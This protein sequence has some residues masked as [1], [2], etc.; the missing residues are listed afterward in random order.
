[1]R[2]LVTIAAASCFLGCATPGSTRNAH[3]A[4]PRSTFREHTPRTK[5]LTAEVIA[6]L[7]S[8]SSVAIS[9]DGDRIAYVVRT[10]PDPTEGA[11]YSRS[12]IWVVSTRGGQPKRFSDPGV[13]SRHP[14]WSKDG[15]TLA[16]LSN[17]AGDSAT[18]I[19]IAPADGGESRVLTRSPSSIATFEWSPTGKE[20]AYLTAAE[21][22]AAEDKAAETGFD[23]QFGDVHGTRRA[24]WVAHAK[25]GD[26]RHVRVGKLHVSA[27]AWSPKGDRFVLRASDRAD[28]DGEMMYSRL[29]TTSA[30][31]GEPKLL[32]KT[33]GKL[34]DMAWSEDGS[35]IAF[36]GAIDIHDP[37]AG[38][39]YVVPSGG[40]TKRALSA[41]YKGTG[42]SLIAATDQVVWMLAN[43]G[44]RTPMIAVTMDGKIEPLLT[45]RGLCRSM[46]LSDRRRKLAASCEAPGHPGEVFVADGLNPPLTRVT[47]SNPNLDAIKLGEREIIRWKAEDGMEIEGVVTRPVGYEKGKKYPLA[48]LVH[49]GPEGVSL[50]GFNTRG[51][52]PVQL[53]ASR[54]Y[55][56]LEPNYRGSQGRGVAFGKADQKDL[57]GKEFTDVI[58]GIDHLAAQGMID[59]DKVGMGGWSYGGYFSGLAATKFT[60]RFKAAMV[61]A[62]ITNWV[63]FTGT[64]EIEHENSLV[65]WNLWPYEHHDLVWDRSPM[66][67]TNDSKTATLI[68]HG[69]KDT[70]VPPEQAYELYRA[71]RHAKTET[72]LVTYPR[73]GHGL[74]ERAHSIDFANRFVDWFD[75]HVKG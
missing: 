8:V 44:T 51:T 29:Y 35:Q 34:G 58:A 48:I 4:G 54:G 22:T 28:V 73:E 30:S 27:F 19:Y 25:T 55:V 65:H 67:H 43:E 42:Q 64:T 52:Y 23:P 3:A 59:P 47:N 39:L 21:A 60:S 32:T 7:A 33:E 56:V 18:Q 71:L 20:M 15:K 66:A 37:T 13:S 75:T 57:G 36:L 53:F 46:V 26:A 5:D 38:V 31:G 17:R 41:D 24:L 45:P 49:G 72:Q 50:N 9:P 70:R 12:V 62:A 11:H 10:P 40:G 14:A 69:A 6:D 16:F 61:G 2:K 74:G 63:S 68:V 1:M